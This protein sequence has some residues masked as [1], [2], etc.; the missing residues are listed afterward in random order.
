MDLLRFFLSSSNLPQGKLIFHSVLAGG[1]NMLVMALLNSAADNASNEAAEVV[2]LILFTLNILVFLLSQRYIWD[3]AIEEVESL[4]NTIRLQLVKNLSGCSMENLEKMGKSDIYAAINQHATTIAQAGIPV[5]VSVQSFILM[6][7]TLAYIALLSIPAFILVLLFMSVAIYV[8]YWRIIFAEIILNKAIGKEKGA[9]AAITDLLEGFKEVKLNKARE[10]DL[11]EHTSTLSRAA[12]DCRVAANQ[13][14]A[15]NYV[16]TQT[17]FYVTIAGMIFML[18]FLGVETF[19]GVVVHVTTA[20]I[21]MIGPINIIISVIPVYANS[22]A[23]LHFIRQI[24]AQ[25]TENQDEHRELKRTLPKF[26][27]LKLTKVVYYFENDNGEQSFHMGPVSLEIKSGE[28]IFFTGGNGSGKTTLIKALVGLYAIKSGTIEYNGRLIHPSDI[29]SYRNQFTAIFS[30]YHL[31]KRFY[32][33]SNIDPDRAQD[34]IALLQLSD[35]TALAEGEFLTQNLSTGQRKRLALIVA[36]LEDRP[37]MILDEWAADQDPAFRKIF[38]EQILPGLRSEG[39]TVL[40]ITH[41]EQYFDLS[42]QR[43]HLIEGKLA[44]KYET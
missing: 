3:I 42:N 18:P 8:A 41:D 26:K 14:I 13:R 10:D 32:G 36:I 2:L 43:H 7:F 25:L 16:A 33:L 40:A 44:E 5:I 4:V 15:M 9:Y 37:I 22:Q 19:A 39:R 6:I 31:F 29:S 20:A 28:I 35:K 30:D 12:K 27:H 24:D 38:Y 34:L 11:I 23:S 17:S 1:T 21:F